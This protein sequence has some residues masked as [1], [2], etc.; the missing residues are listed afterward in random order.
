MWKMGIAAAACFALVACGDGRGERALT[1]AGIGAASGAL[2][3]AL[4]D[5]AIGPGAILGGLAGAGIGA[6]TSNDF[7]FRG[8]DDRR[9]RKRKRRRHYDDD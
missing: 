6:A 4:I 8:F 2:G 5:G 7:S 9:P 1:G 3:A